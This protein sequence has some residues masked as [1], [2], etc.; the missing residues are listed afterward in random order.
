MSELSTDGMYSSGLPVPGAREILEALGVSSF[1]RKSKTL[2]LVCAGV[3][4]GGTGASGSTSTMDT[5][6]VV[7]SGSSST[8]AALGLCPFG[9]AILTD[10]FFSLYSAP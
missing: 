10:F 9:S 2:T 6:V 4:E 7:V 3:A 8:Y 1:T 5:A